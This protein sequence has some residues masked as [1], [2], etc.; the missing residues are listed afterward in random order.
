MRRT[1]DSSDKLDGFVGDSVGG[2]LKMSHGAWP[3]QLYGLTSFQ[4]NATHTH[5]YTYILAHTYLHRESDTH[6]SH[7]RLCVVWP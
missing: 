1:K 4:L 6:K 7:R 2:T 3:P 5:T